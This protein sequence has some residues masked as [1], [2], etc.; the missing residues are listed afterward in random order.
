MPSSLGQNSTQLLWSRG[1]IRSHALAPMFSELLAKAFLRLRCPLQRFQRDLEGSLTICADC[2]GWYSAQPFRHP[3]T[4]LRHAFF[5]CAFTFAH[6]AR[7]A[8]T[9]LLRPAAEIVR[10]GLAF[11]FAHRAFC[12]K[13]IFRR[14]ETLMVCLPRF[15]PLEPGLPKAA[16]AAS[17]RWTSFCARSRSVLNCRTT[18]DRFPICCFPLGSAS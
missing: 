4:H 9:I 17:M 5:C 6:L 7:C 12:A 14:A 15:E 1:L 11:C 10:L 3:E 2:D 18:T 16:S 8:A 13:L